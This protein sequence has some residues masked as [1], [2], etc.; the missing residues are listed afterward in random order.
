MVLESVKP[1]LM[2]NFLSILSWYHY[3][4]A[5]YYISLMYNFC[6]SWEVRLTF[7]PL[8]NC[9]YMWIGNSATFNLVLSVSLQSNPTC[10][11][12]PPCH[13]KPMGSCK[14]LLWKTH[15]YGTSSLINSTLVV[16]ILISKKYIDIQNWQTQKLK[17]LNTYK[18]IPSFLWLLQV[19]LVAQRHYYQDLIFSSA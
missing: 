7:M 18:I 16:I 14:N 3:N 8:T 1:S 6:T 12:L 4:E 15:T 13:Q 2:T 17:L 9:Y 19:C 5:F 10:P 11:A